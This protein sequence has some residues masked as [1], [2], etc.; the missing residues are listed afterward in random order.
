LKRARRR[1][2]IWAISNL[3]AFPDIPGFFNYDSMAIWDFVFNAQSR[4]DVRGDF[5]EIGV[6]K[7][8]SAVLGASYM[9]PEEW[10]VFADINPMP[11]TE[12]MIATFR[13]ERNRYLVGLSTALRRIPAVQRHFGQCRWVHIDGDHKGYT[14]SNDLNLAADLITKNGIICMDDFFNFRYPQLTAAVYRFLFSRQPEFQM[15]FAGGNKCYICRSAAYERYEALIRS[16]FLP[17]ISSLED[18]GI[19]LELDK[20]SYASDDGCFSVSWRIAERR[21]LG[22]DENPDEIVY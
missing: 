12:A 1:D 11:E 8:R 3:S 13:P 21:L 14:V 7:G 10:C 2:T 20:S 15:L 9:R 5:F 17:V 16:D 6:Y 18:R 19:R 4:L 22:L